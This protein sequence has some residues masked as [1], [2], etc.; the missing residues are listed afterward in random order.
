M[1]TDNEGYTAQDT[2]D[3]QGMAYK[4]EM[5]KRCGLSIYLARHDLVPY[6][7]TGKLESLLCGH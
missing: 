2:W 7:S 1:L 6:D 4:I 5:L 3:I